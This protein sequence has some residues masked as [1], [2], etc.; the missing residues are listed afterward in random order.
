MLAFQSPAVYILSRTEVMKEESAVAMRQK[1]YSRILEIGTKI[2]ESIL[3]SLSPGDPLPSE[4]KIAERTGETHNRVHR[5]LQMLIDDGLLHSSGCRRGI[6]LL[7]QEYSKKENRNILRNKVRLVFFMPLDPKSMQARTWQRVCENFRLL[8]PQV[9][10]EYCY[11]QTDYPP[12]A[13]LYLTWPPLTDCSLFRPLDPEEI[14]SEEVTQEELLPRILEVGVQYG[15]HYAIPVLHSPTAFWGHR[16]L[17]ARHKLRASEFTDPLDFFRWGTALESTN[18]CAMGF[19]FYGFTYHAVQWGVEVRRE[20]MTFRIDPEKLKTFLTDIGPIVKAPHLPYTPFNFYNYFH[21]GQLALLANYLFSLPI[22]ENRFQL[23][24]QPLR[25]DGFACQ[26]AFMFSAGARTRHMDMVAA[27]IRFI[28]GKRSQKLL[29]YP[30]IRFSVRKDMYFRQHSELERHAGVSIPPYDFRGFV[31]QLDL[32]FYL[33]TGAYLY[34]ECAN[35]LC[36]FTHL[37]LA[38]ER[39]CS[40]DIRKMRRKWLNSVSPQVVRK[41]AAYVDTFTKKVP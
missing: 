29:F 25:K 8:H 35:Y 38:M 9:E 41:F 23:L 12:G 36:G 39:M 20:D 6:F 14:F 5:A 4:R 26:A 19:I 18:Q 32:D 31:P 37:E 40:I 17:L 33:P 3:S 24:G 1:S 10:F 16:N 34:S 28:L 7:P 30:E 13:D 2:R 11:D 27:L 22:N 21:R 15:R